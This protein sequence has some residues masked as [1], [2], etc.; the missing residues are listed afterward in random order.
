MSKNRFIVAVI[1][2]GTMAGMFYLAFRGGSAPVE[3]ATEASL[4]PASIPIL[5]DTQSVDFIE[6]V[7]FSPPVTDK[8]QKN[9]AFFDLMQKNGFTPQEIN[10]IAKAAKPIFNF[11]RIYPGQ[12]Y[13]IFRNEDGTFASLEFTV[14]EETYI[15]VTSGDGELSVSEKKFPF[16][17]VTRSASGLITH[18]LFASLS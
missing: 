15:E 10:E 11:R 5:V 12:S 17:L 8:V 18:S 7:S 3:P 16:E 2:V 9:E 1:M 14:D 4:G 13:E 6:A